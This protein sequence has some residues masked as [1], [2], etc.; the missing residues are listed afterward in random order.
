[1]LKK[2]N[3]TSTANIEKESKEGQQSPSERLKFGG[4]NL[5]AVAIVTN[6]LA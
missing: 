4:G 1:L 6:K 2:K 5:A 3:V